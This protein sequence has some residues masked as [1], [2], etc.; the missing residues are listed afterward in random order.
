MQDTATTA[1]VEAS[2]SVPHPKIFSG[3][4][5]LQASKHSSTQ[6]ETRSEE[7]CLLLG[8]VVIPQRMQRYVTTAHILKQHQGPHRTTTAVYIPISMSRRQEL[9]ATGNKLKSSV[10]YLEEVNNHT[11]MQFEHNTVV[12]AQES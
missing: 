7:V 1:A 10:S 3:H 9:Q 11:I 2:I 8:R 4:S 12:K 5:S 6:K